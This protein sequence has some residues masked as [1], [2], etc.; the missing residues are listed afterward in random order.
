MQVIRSDNCLWK[1]KSF[2]TEPQKFA[3]KFFHF[4]VNLKY[5]EEQQNVILK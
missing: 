4:K 3:Y 5:D 2:I 1:W